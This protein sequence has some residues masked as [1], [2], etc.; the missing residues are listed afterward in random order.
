LDLHI[1]TSSDFVFLLPQILIN[2][3]INFLFSTKVYHLKRRCLPADPS[4]Y[5]K[6]VI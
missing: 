5:W 1:R 2:I 3:F 4:S 6:E